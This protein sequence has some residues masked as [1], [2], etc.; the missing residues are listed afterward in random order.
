M[1][2]QRIAEMVREPVQSV[3]SRAAPVH[4]GTQEEKKEGEEGGA[5]LQ[6]DKP[7]PLCCARSADMFSH[8]GTLRRSR[9]AHTHRSKSSFENVRDS[10]LLG[11]LQTLALP[12]TRSPAP[13][14]RSPA[15]LR[16]R[17]AGA[18]GAGGGRWG[19]CLRP[20]GA[21]SSSPSSS[22]D[23]ERTS[24]R[25]RREGGEERGGRGGGCW[26]ERENSFSKEKL[27]GP[28]SDMDSSQK[29]L[30][31]QVQAPPTA[32]T[33]PSHCRYK[34]LPL[35]VQAPPTAGTSS[36]HCRY[37][38]LPLQ[39]QAPP[40][41]GTSP[42][43]CRYK[44]L[45]LQVQAPPTT[46]TSPSHCRY[47]LLP[48][49]T[50][51]ERP[52][53]SEEP[54]R[55]TPHTETEKER[56]EVC[57]RF[58][59]P[60]QANEAN[61]ANVANDANA[62]NEANVANDTNNATPPSLQD[63]TPTNLQDLNQN[64][65]EQEDSNTDS[66]P[67]LNQDLD[68]HSDQNPDQDQ[69]SSGYTELV[70]QSFVDRLCVEEDPMLKAQNATSCWAEVTSCFRPLSYRSALLTS[71][72]NRPLEPSVLRR[73]KQILARVQP[74]T[75]ALHM[76]QADCQVGGI[77]EQRMMG[78]SSGVE[79]LTL[80]HGRRLR[81]DLLER[82]ETMA[83]SLAVQV[84]GC[85]G[86]LEERASLINKLIFTAQ[87]LRVSVGNLFGFGAV[88]RA[89][90][91]PQTHT[92]HSH[93]SL[94]PVT[95]T[96]HS[97]L[98]LTPV[99]H[100]Y[101][102]HSHLSLTPVTH[103]CHSHLHLSLTL[104][105][106]THTYTCHLHLSLTPVTHTYT[107]HSHLH[108][109]LTLTPVTY[110][111]HSHLSLTLTPVTHTYTCHSHLSLTL[112]PVT[113]TCHSHLSLTPVTHTYTCHSHL[114][115]TLTPVTHTCHSHLSL[116]LTPVTYTC[117]SHLSL[118]PVTHT[119]TCHFHLSLT[120]VTYTCH[121]TCHSHLHLSLRPVTHTCHSHSH[122]SLTPVTYTCH[123]H[124]SLTLTPV[125]QTYTC[126]SHLSLTSVTSPVT[127]TYTCHFTCHSHL[128]LS[129]RPVT[130]TCHFCPLQVSRLEQTWAMLRQRHTEGAVLYEKTLRPFMKSLNE[131]RESCP[132]SNT[133]F[134]HVLPLLWLM[135]RETPG[136]A[137]RTGDTL[138]DVPRTGDTL[139]DVPRT[140]D[141]QGDAPEVLPQLWD[142]DLGLDGLMFH[143]SAARTM[144][145]LGNVYRSNTSSK[146]QGLVPDPD[147]A[148]VFST[149]FQLRLLW[150][151]K[152]ATSPQA[153]RFYK[154]N[155]VLSALSYRLEPPRTRT[156]AGL[157]QD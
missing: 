26:R 59:D 77:L 33:S 45:P 5:W 19:K 153:Q 126:H 42:S 69:D 9:R 137:V 130:H 105:P 46:G 135:E 100:T 131:G 14:P 55:T 8:V 30:P 124:L 82:L 72:E 58:A 143:L 107:C 152:G 48:L 65:K 95:Y 34:L 85:T 2:K 57:H 43:H 132:L 50:G 156:K 16:L 71:A 70:P 64:M 80:P 38:P 53:A 83:M 56:E 142:S 157:K 79:L 114:S 39:V 128:H 4:D 60:N 116:T 23:G 25:V 113:Y 147:L 106:V 41:A 103:T 88:M 31:L 49:Q 127:H 122:L 111:C 144:A 76:T 40:T 3:Q 21:G 29:P 37:K 63:L 18:A 86:T 28:N 67:D 47:K 146:L 148:Q 17:P 54:S 121:F 99:T 44:P 149:D 1:K 125:T 133:C 140:G 13:L 7:R 68:Q 89:L 15:Y 93:L 6:Q 74:Q 108:L 134:P 102:C 101:T 27:S 92:C 151:H 118:T 154:L 35:Q 62:A 78:V 96:C 138:R 51:E 75:A 136:S 145:Q 139:R 110:T 10:P 61:E 129:L 73:V 94:T 22:S 36:S 150:G 109:S 12:F 24:E 141:T 104:T 66:K 84:L 120:L 97:H 119:Y 155:Q 52:L 32:G 115:L 20:D 11:A 87:E 91:L 90:Q 81:L 98:S 123:S 117:H 112:T